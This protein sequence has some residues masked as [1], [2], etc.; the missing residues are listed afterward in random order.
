MSQE[1]IQIPKGWNK[2]TTLDV[3]QDPKMSIRIGP[4]GSSLKKHEL[5]DSGI[6]VLFIENVVHNKF[7]YKSGKFITPEK[8]NELKGFT[9]KPNDILVTMMGTIGR[10]CIVPEDI[11]AAI[12]S[13]HLLKISLDQKKVLP[14]YFALLLQSPITFNQMKKESRGISMPGLNSKIIKNLEFILP[15]IKIQKKIVAKLDHILGELEVKKKEILSLI[16]QNKERIDFFEKNWRMYMITKNIVNHPLQKEWN[17]V[18]FDDVCSKITY[19]FTNPMPHVEKGMWLITAKNIKN[20]NINYSN[21]K[22]T[23]LKS[24]K[25]LITDK[26]RPK[27]GTVLI[28]KDGTLGRVGIVDKE[29]ICISQ[30]VGSL[31]AIQSKI[32]PLFLAFILESSEIQSKIIDDNKR[33]TIGHVQI[34]KLAKWTFPLPPIPIQKEIIQNIK[35]DEEK[36]KE[37]KIQFEKI[38]QNYDSKINYINHIQSSILDSA[39]S[40]KLIQ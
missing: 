22:K 31:Q 16:E 24:F 14:K 25:E 28:T 35:K 37:Q 5:T 9:V 32:S 6:R 30:S 15:D 23:D 27:V 13:S 12:I 18:T 38:K 29:N 8:Y 39:F 4:F 1:E 26:S 17:V 33:S 36:F 2:V 3:V 40:G 7:E 10:I 34:T 19:G 21:A 11:G 20:G